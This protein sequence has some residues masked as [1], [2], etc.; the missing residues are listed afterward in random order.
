M[1]PDPSI[2]RRGRRSA[3]LGVLSLLAAAGAAAAGPPYLTDD[4]EPTDLGHWE[5]Y[6]FGQGQAAQGALAGE[7]G[8][9]LNYGAAKDLQLTAVIPAAFE[10]PKGVRSDGF[11]GGTGI[12][13]F[14]AK[15]KILHKS[16]A[17]FSPDVSLFP[18]VFIT[19]DT[20]FGPSHPNLFL[21][22][23]VEKDFGPWSV[24]GGAGPQFNPGRGQENFWQGG[25]AVI[26]SFGDDVQIGAEVYAAGPN[27]KAG[28]RFETVNLGLQ[29]RLAPH[30]SLLSSGGPGLYDGKP[31]ADLYL[32][33]KAD[34]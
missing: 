8:V 17:G 1:R 31:G 19:T 15:Y 11:R 10:N 30:W 14:A 3:L 24:F 22:V 27:T 2:R 25:A 12:F 33:L 6:A 9:D 32:A 16:D 7:T 28:G 23:W 21:P 13:E 4:P 18:R 26:R 29:L 20:R 5:I 34:Y